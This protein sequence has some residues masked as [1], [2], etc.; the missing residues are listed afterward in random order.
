MREDDIYD[1]LDKIQGSSFGADVTSVADAIAADGNAG[2][3]RVG[4]FRADETDHFVVDDIFA[5]LLWGVLISD[6]FVC[7]SAFD[8]LSGLGGV[9]ANTLAEAAKFIGVEMVL[10]VFVGGILAELVIL[11]GLAGG[12]AKDGEGPVVDEFVWVFAACS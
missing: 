7:T 12:G 2:A 10:D 6:D 9:G 11:Q 1:N 5:M 4:F 3:I 8:T